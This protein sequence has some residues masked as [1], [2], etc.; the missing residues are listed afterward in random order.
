MGPAKEIVGRREPAGSWA[1]EEPEQEATPPRFVKAKLRKDTYLM[2]N[3]SNGYKTQYWEV[4][5]DEIERRFAKADGDLLEQQQQEAE[6]ALG[7]R[8]SRSEG[9]THPRFRSTRILL[10]PP[11]PEYESSLVDEVYKMI[12]KDCNGISVQELQHALAKNPAL[13]KL[14]A[15]C[16]H[17]PPDPATLLASMDNSK[18]GMVS[19]DEFRA[20]IHTQAKSTED[21]DA[22][23]EYLVDTLKSSKESAV[24][25]LMTPTYVVARLIGN[26]SARHK[27]PQEAEKP[28]EPK[29]ASHPDWLLDFFGCCG[30]RPKE[31]AAGDGKVPWRHEMI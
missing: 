20:Y 23:G 12:D 15:G 14:L 29:E 9:P 27:L 30:V 1:G 5:K 4:D 11:D 3:V 13:L 8:R 28:K 6:G 24:R 7:P 2:C 18:D 21:G 25:L 17:I 22:I 16:D 19:L 31:Q 10:G 26:Q